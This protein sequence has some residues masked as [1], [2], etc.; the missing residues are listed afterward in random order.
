MT[1]HSELLCCVVRCAEQGVDVGTHGQGMEEKG[2][3]TWLCFYT[4]SPKL[5]N[6]GPREHV[7]LV[8]Q[9]VVIFEKLLESNCDSVFMQKQS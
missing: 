9:H 3:T 4:K 2:E 7:N 5:H 1:W 6:D 8:T